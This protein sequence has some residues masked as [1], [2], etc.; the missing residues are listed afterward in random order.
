MSG[1]DNKRARGSFNSGNGEHT[2]FMREMLDYL[3]NKTK[4]KE[5]SSTLGFQWYFKGVEQTWINEGRAYLLDP[6][7]HKPKDIFSLELTQEFHVYC[8]RYL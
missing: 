7:K 1:S 4:W 8:T 2:A 3:N 5:S 6:V